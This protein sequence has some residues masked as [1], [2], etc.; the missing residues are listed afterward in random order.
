[1][2]AWLISMP[3][4]SV[5]AATEPPPADARPR[6]RRGAAPPLPVDTLFLESFY[7]P[8]TP[9][10]V[11]GDGFA[12]SFE[13]PSSLDGTD[14]GACG[15]D[16]A[17]ALAF[18]SRYGFVVFRG[19]ATAAACAASRAEVWDVLE[20]EGAARAAVVR[21]DEEATW[22]ALSSDTYGLAQRPA[23]FSRQ[24]LANRQGE[25]LV[26]CFALLLGVDARVA[27]PAPRRPGLLVSHDRFCFYRPAGANPSW[28]TRENLHLDLHPWAFRGRGAFAEVRAALEG[29]RFE[30][31]RDFARETNWVAASTGPHL[32]GV[33]SLSDNRAE[34]GGTV[35]VPGFASRFDAWAEALDRCCCDGCSRSSEERR[36]SCSNGEAMDDARGDTRRRVFCCGGVARHSDASAAAAR[37]RGSPRAPARGWLI[38]RP[39]GGGSW[40]FGAGDAALSA[41]AVRVPLRE[42]SLLVWDQRGAHGARPNSSHFPRYA[43]FI[44][45]FTAQHVSD[46]RA[47]ARAACLRREAAAEGIDVDLSPEEG[48][49]ITPLG[50]RVFGL[51]WDAAG[52][53]GGGGGAGGVA[54]ADAFETGG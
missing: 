51:D 27:A 34:D 19:A 23:L 46:G 30:K 4:P 10:P 21:R 40:K 6:R 24:L 7:P 33:L 32:Q 22:H 26:S 1:M 18:Y 5:P 39:H 47:R 49:I 14:A 3:S 13:C 9:C 45:A 31:L 17:A 20:A 2:F 41:R 48:G 11:D 16:A 54:T 25:A 38:P 15:A 29:L 43:Q 53:G 44:K 35:V 42:G 52:D 8:V 37:A 36:A 28:G 50:R 12:V